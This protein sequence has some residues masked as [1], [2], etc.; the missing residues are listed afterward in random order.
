MNDSK[1][2][3]V[4]AGIIAQ[5]GFHYQKLVFVF[6]ILSSFSIGNV[7]TYEGV[8]D[9]EIS[10]EDDPLIQI[11]VGKDNDAIQ[12]KSG[13]V[14]KENYGKVVGNWLLSD[15]LRP[16]LYIENS[17]ETVFEGVEAVD[18][19]VE[20]FNNGKDCKRSSIVRRVYDRF[21]GESDSD[22]KLRTAVTD[23][24]RR[25]DIRKMSSEKLWSDSLN[26]FSRC[27]CNDIK[28]FERAKEER[29]YRFVDE[30]NAQI[31]NNIGKKMSCILGYNDVVG[32]IFQT[33]EE[34]SDHKYEIDVNVVKKNKEKIAKKLFSEGKLREIKQL[35]TID[36]RQGFVI[37]EIVKELLYKDFRDIYVDSPNSKR[38]SAIEAE[39]FSNHEDTLYEITDLSPKRDYYATIKKDLPSDLMPDSALFRNGCYVYLTSD[40]VPEDQKITW[41]GAIE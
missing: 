40:D 3:D 39:A 27:Y 12:V 5:Y 32:I 34:I 13:T 10:Q 1:H 35:L 23:V 30:I 36:Q 16:V 21:H 28:L 26:L 29:F 33:M 41:G 20:F 25:A 24:L 6:T 8:D 9:V 17:I 7:Y 2:K 14:R 18:S 31:E 38:I 19:L 22:D 37:K 4:D 11:K 15:A